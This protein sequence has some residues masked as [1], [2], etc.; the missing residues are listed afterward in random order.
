MLFQGK[1]LSSF[2]SLFKLSSGEE[3]KPSSLKDIYHKKQR[4]NKQLPEW[5]RISPSQPSHPPEVTLISV[6]VCFAVWVHKRGK[7]SGFSLVVLFIHKPTSTHHNTKQSLLHYLY[8]YTIPIAMVSQCPFFCLNHQRSVQL[9]YTP[10]LIWM[11]YRCGQTRLPS[12]TFGFYL[13]GFV[14]NCRD[15][16]PL[17]K[18]QNTQAHNLQILGKSTSSPNYWGSTQFCLWFLLPAN[19]CDPPCGSSVISVYISALISVKPCICL[20]RM[21]LQA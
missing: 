3:M 9:L 8:S 17:K 7:L 5:N 1:N 16:F 18:R 2:V 15:F 19:C 13:K 6:K 14:H 20:D 12:F 11:S 21:I 4:E 10:I